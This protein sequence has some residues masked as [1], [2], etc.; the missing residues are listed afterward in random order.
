MIKRRVDSAIEDMH[1]G[2]VP[3]RIASGSPWPGAKF[4]QIGTLGAAGVP[5][6]LDG[7]GGE[8]PIMAP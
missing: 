3:K 7:V 2:K 4:A 6:V 8:P 5:A 1:Y